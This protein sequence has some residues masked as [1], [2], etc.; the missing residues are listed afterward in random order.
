MSSCLCSPRCS[1]LPTIRKL[2]Y[3]ITITGVSVVVALIVG[4]LETLKLIGDELGLTDGGGFW[5]TIG[6][7]ND[8]FGVLGYVVIASSSSPGLGLSRSTRSCVTTSWKS[9]SGRRPFSLANSALVSGHSA[10]PERR[11]TFLPPRAQRR[12][13]IWSMPHGLPDA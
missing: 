13:R 2:Y 8:N 10:W 12:Q 7:I 9:R 11:Y 4:G 3:N 1:T 5:G 6:D